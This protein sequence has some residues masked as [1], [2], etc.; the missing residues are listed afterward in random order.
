M[1]LFILP[2]HCPNCNKILLAFEPGINRMNP[3]EFTCEHPNHFYARFVTYRGSK[4]LLKD[5]RRYSCTSFSF[6]I[7]Q[8]IFH[9]VHTIDGVRM[10][11]SSPGEIIRSRYQKWEKEFESIEEY[12][13]CVKQNRL[14]L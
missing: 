14:F 4:E 8:T 10:A 9:F 5:G 7:D 12:V 1:K 6:L 3:G 13:D 11:T 2:K